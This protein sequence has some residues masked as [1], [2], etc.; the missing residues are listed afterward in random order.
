MKLLKPGTW[1]LVARYKLM[2]SF[3]AHLWTRTFWRLGI[4]DHVGNIWVI[5]K[6]EASKWG[7]FLFGSFKSSPKRAHSKDTSPETATLSD[8]LTSNG[9]SFA[10]FRSNQACSSDGF[11]TYLRQP[12]LDL[13]FW[14]K[15]WPPETKTPPLPAGTPP[16]SKTWS[17]AAAACKSAE[18]TVRPNRSARGAYIC[19][20]A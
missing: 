18:R 8:F 19:L 3:E 16:E 2:P 14:D 12:V 20:A 6:G 13:C 7:G 11:W 4:F 1:W 9:A 17:A 5:K 15:N 10:C